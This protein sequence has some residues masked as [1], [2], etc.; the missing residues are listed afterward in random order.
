[1]VLRISSRCHYTQGVTQ[2]RLGLA[3]GD[4][5][6]A[7]AAMSRQLIEHGLAWS[8]DE[9][10]VARCLRNRE[11]VV[12]AA[13]DRRRVIGFAIMEFYALHAH[14]NLLAVQPGYQRQGVG[15]QLLEW[16]EASA[17][18][19]GIFTVHLEVRANNDG[20]QAFYD[21]L[22]Y[23]SMGRKAAYYDGREDAV[24]MTHDLTVPSTSA[25]QRP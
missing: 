11:C 22:G 24:R 13:R 23:R 3:H 12:L 21:K 15:R 19:A 6:P 18:T 25:A 16:L 5:A 9:D 17:R 8:W 4:D 7:I 2:V 1:L 14:L 20:A 10:R